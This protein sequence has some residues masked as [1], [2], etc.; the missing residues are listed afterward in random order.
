MVRRAT[1]S[2]A[3]RYGAHLPSRLLEGYQRARSDPAPLDGSDE[4]ALID[5][6]LVEIVGRLTSGETVGAWVR[7]AGLVTELDQVLA[8]WESGDD[9]D[10][11]AYAA[12]QIAR[13][14]V[15]L[16]HEAVS[17]EHAWREI[18]ELIDQRSKLAE[19]ERRRRLELDETLTREQTRLFVGAVFEILEQHVTD[20]TTL[21]AIA[22]DVGALGAG[23]V[24]GAVPRAV[25]RRS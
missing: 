13:S 3:G 6:R 14:I 12:F 15:G 8:G 1:V 20:R 2:A 17:D 21:A 11:A 24:R 23:D 18:R 19:T 7:L 5:T 22:A 25:A 4:L 10:E 16:V 9:Q